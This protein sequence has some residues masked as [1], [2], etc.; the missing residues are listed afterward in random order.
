[1]AWLARRAAVGF[2]L[3]M[4]STAVAHPPSRATEREIVRI[5]GHPG[6][7]RDGGEHAIVLAALAADHPFA[8]TEFRVF[9][10]GEGD[11]PDTPPA[12]GQRFVLQGSREL[13]ARFGS[14]RPEQTVTIL[15]DHHP[16]SKDLFLLTLDLCPPR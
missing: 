2:L 3:L 9:G 5:Q 10:F 1:M 16:G 14:A 7:A 12:S 4:V 6:A 13:L 11:V 8:A 15:A